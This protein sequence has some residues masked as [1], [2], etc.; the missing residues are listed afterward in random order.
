MPRIETVVD[1]D[2]PCIPEVQVVD[3]T[4]EIIGSSSQTQTARHKV[5]VT[6]HRLGTSTASAV[7][8]I[9]AIPIETV[10]DQ[11]SSIPPETV[12]AASGSSEVT[13]AD[14]LNSSD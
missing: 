5:D 13:V 9:D 3:E 12:V 6:I 14:R 2:V 11:Q 7:Q 10:S 1:P 4:G 8:Q